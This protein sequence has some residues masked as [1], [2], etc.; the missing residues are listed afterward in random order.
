MGGSA[1]DEDMIKLCNAGKRYSGQW[2]LRGFNL[3][4][5]RG[6]L[7]SVIGSSGCGKTTALKLMNGLLTP[8]EGE[9]YVDGENIAQ[10][11][12]CL[13]RRRIG[14][15]IQGVGLFPH[16]DVCRNISYVPGLLHSWKSR[17]ER[18]QKSAALL[19][20]VGLERDMLSRYPSELSGGQC[21]RVGLARAL[22][23]EPE[24]LL[25]D[26]PFGAVDELTR[27]TLQTQIRQIQRRLK[28][29]VVFVTHDIREALLLGDRVLVMQPQNV[30]RLA[31]PD[32]LLRDPQ[33]DFV[34]KLV[35][36]IQS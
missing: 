17:C 21:Q 34:K 2:I 12:K 8:D 20:L 1:H 4:V 13:L 7:M 24:I 6:E 18:E 22:A 5:R 35:S 14:Y 11:N 16:M 27:R 25:M 36:G 33:T 30:I 23:A 28:I 19:E 31:S 26:E 15:A 10:L 29:T 3:C 9:V 32:E